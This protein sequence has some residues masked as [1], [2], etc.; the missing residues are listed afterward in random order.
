MVRTGNQDWLKL[1]LTLAKFQ[2]ALHEMPTNKSPDING[3][4]VDCYQMFCEVINLDLVI[5]WAEFL[6]SKMLPPDVQADQ[7]EELAPN[8]AARHRL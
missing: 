5:I 6:G 8:I 7:P 4:T 2:E 3:L 1:P